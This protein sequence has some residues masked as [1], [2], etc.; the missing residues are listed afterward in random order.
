MQ[1]PIWLSQFQFRIVRRASRRIR[2]KVCL[3]C[4][5]PISGAFYISTLGFL[6][7]MPVQKG[8]KAWRV[9]GTC[10]ARAVPCNIHN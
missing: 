9:Y 5:R 6:L 3:F 7:A 8:F 10:M 1:R 4:S 2:F